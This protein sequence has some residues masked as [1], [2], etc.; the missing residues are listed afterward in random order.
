MCKVVQTSN[1]LNEK[2]FVSLKKANVIC[3]ELASDMSKLVELNT[4]IS[5]DVELLTMSLKTK[6]DELT[7]LKEES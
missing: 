5:N 3:K 4:S 6:D 1:E 2:H 7:I